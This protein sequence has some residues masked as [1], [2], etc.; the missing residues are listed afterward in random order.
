[1]PVPYTFGTATAAIPLSQLDSNFATAV[2]IGNTAVQLGNTVTTLNNMTLANVTISSGNVTITN[3]SVTTANVSGTANVST[4]VII[5]NESVGG[6]TTVTGNISANNATLTTSLT[7]SGGTA[8]GVAYLNT[9]KAL[10]TG[11]AFVF[12]GTNLSTTGSVSLNNN[13]GNAYYLR[14]AAGS[15]TFGYLYSDATNLSLVNQQNGYLNFFTN[16]AEKMRLDASGNLLVGTTSAGSFKFKA[17]GTGGNL[18]GNAYF[19]GLFSDGSASIKGVGLG[20]DNTSQTGIVYAETASAAS[21][22]AF[23]TFSGSAWGERARID[24]SGNLLVGTTSTVGSAR[25]AIV[26][27]S[28]TSATRAVN[29]QNSSGTN[30]LIVLNDGQV[31]ANEIG[32]DTGTALV[33]NS[34]GYIKKLTSSIRYKKDVEP[35][36]IGL[37][38]V[39]GLSPVKYNMKNGDTAQVGFIAEDFPDGR[40]VSH[41]MIDAQ[42]S[43]KGTQIESVNYANITAPLVKAIQ[44]Q[45]ALIT[46]LTA[47]ITALENK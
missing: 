5:G 12:D 36:D 45:Q 1:M 29:L 43:S 19:V 24:S 6:N 37:D 9:S 2:T 31:Y 21:N 25:V 39:M 30:L 27:S 47:R 7:L 23:W 4:M 33:L 3:V 20:Y 26:S 34:G 28:N 46:S 44:E 32:S 38:F 22:L 10:T 8:N 35:I 13:S 16:N 41:S 17:V 14:N 15:T 42:D 40:F 18:A 11:T